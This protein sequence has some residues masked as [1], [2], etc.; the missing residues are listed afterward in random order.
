MISTGGLDLRVV[1]PCISEKQWIIDN[2]LPSHSSRADDDERLPPEGL[3][4]RDLLVEQ[5]LSLVV[6]RVLLRLE[7]NVTHKLPYELPS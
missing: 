4:E 6:L 3:H 1:S 7:E 5:H 2:I